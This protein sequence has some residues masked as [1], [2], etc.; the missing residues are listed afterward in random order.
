[1]SKSSVLN[2]TKKIKSKGTSIKSKGTSKY[3]ITKKQKQ[4]IY[5]AESFIP[6]A[7]HK[8][9]MIS[10]NPI[11]S[12]ESMQKIFGKELSEIHDPPDKA[13]VARGIKWVRFLHGGKAELHFVPP[14]N[15]NH[16]KMLIKIATEQDNQHPLKSQFYENHVG[17]YVPDL[18]DIIIKTLEHKIPYNMNQREDGLYQLYVDIPAALDYLEIDSLYLNLNAIHKKYPTFK[19]MNFFEN[20]KIVNKMVK[21]QMGKLKTYSYTDPN[22]KDAPRTIRIKSDNTLTIEG[23]DTPDGKKWKIK[24]KINKNNDTTLDF[25]SKGGPKSVKAHITP[26]KVTFSDGNKWTSNKKSLYSII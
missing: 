10:F 19:I 9:T 18:T 25:S 6:Y 16:N 13:L 1:M 3:K 2:K 14:F 20:T 23:K 15:L 17:I 11:K 7:I 12:C 4:K 26:D 5:A 22:H 8:F 21:K 24:G